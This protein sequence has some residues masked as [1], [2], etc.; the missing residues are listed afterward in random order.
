[1]DGPANLQTYYVPPKWSSRKVESSG[2]QEAFQ[3]SVFA[4]SR[5][6][7][8]HMPCLH[9]QELL[10]RSLLLRAPRG[11]CAPGRVGC[12]EGGRRDGLGADRQRAGSKGF[13]ITPWEYTHWVLTSFR[14]IS[15]SNRVILSHSGSFPKGV[16]V[17]QKSSEQWAGHHW[18]GDTVSARLVNPSRPNL[19]DLEGGRGRLVINRIYVRPT[20]EF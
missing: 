6:S 4:F 12:E 20:C 16:I 10:Q 17:I 7:C 14:H 3:P 11:A 2:T 1:M 19:V 9:A 5:T 13:C 15:G 8:L 18:H